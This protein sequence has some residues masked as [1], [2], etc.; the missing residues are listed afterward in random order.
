MRIGI[1]KEALVGETRVA[2]SPETVKKLVGLGHQVVVARGAGL[3]ASMVDSAYEAAGASLADQ[4]TAL[5][6]DMVLKVRIPTDAEL[7]QMK[8]GAV[9]VGMLSP[10]DR[11]GLERLAAAGLTAFAM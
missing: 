9:L 7:A 1:P 6:C 2:G 4:A 11:P 3:G 8:K 10:F 5:G